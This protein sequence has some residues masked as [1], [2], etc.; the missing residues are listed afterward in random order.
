MALSTL[1][2]LRHNARRRD[3][4]LD[5][6]VLAVAMVGDDPTQQEN[7]WIEGRLKALEAE[8]ARDERIMDALEQ[9][10]QS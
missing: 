9:G 7:D 2:L 5:A 4:E 3:R 6:L 10:A 1:C 8:L